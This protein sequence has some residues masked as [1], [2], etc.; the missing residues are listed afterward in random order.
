M[1]FNR[2]A[3]YLENGNQAEQSHATSPS[4]AIFKSSWTENTGSLAD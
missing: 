1:P 2:L 4:S 3:C